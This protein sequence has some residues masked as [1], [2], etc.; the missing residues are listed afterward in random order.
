[1]V[2]KNEDGGT[3][4]EVLEGDGL[5]GAKVLKETY[6]KSYTFKTFSGGTYLNLRG[7]FYGEGREI[8]RRGN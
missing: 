7:T 5:R 1:M 6:I 4:G 2:R 3:A 8:E